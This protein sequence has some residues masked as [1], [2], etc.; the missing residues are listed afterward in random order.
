MVKQWADA[1]REEMLNEIFNP[2]RTPDGSD[3]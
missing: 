2:D 1:T 3:K